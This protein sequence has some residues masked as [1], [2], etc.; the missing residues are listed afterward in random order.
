MGE[1]EW[2]DEEGPEGF[3]G[4][5]RMGEEVKEMNLGGNNWQV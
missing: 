3:S 4:E 5:E 2:E 1:R